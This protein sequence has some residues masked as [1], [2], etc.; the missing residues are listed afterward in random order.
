MTN[1]ITFGA[2][3]RYLIGLVLMWEMAGGISVIGFS[4]GQTRY[5]FHELFRNYGQPTPR[6]NMKHSPTGAVML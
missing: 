6:I 5:N 4:T 3:P 1:L 2:F